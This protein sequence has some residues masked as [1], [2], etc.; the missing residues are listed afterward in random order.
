MGVS[1]SV[2][3]SHNEYWFTNTSRAASF[4]NRPVIRILWKQY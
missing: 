1:E 3:V 4:Y 2:K